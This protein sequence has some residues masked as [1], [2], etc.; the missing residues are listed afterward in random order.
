[1]EEKDENPI[2]ESFRTY[3]D[4]MKELAECF[5]RLEKSLARKRQLEEEEKEAEQEKDEKD[6]TD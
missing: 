1:M 6:T 5:D 3:K 2:V 4:K